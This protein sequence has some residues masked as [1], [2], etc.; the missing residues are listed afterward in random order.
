MN[1]SEIESL[2]QQLF[3]GTISGDD[4]D[5]LE[6]Q[7][8]ERPE[9]T[10]LYRDY[11]LLHHTLGTRSRL[12][13]LLTPSVEATPRLKRRM[14]K[15][16][17]RQFVT[18]LAAAIVVSAVAVTLLR[19]THVLDPRAT[20]TLVSA[21]GS[22]VS[23]DDPEGEGRSPDGAELPLGSTVRLEQGTVEL[24]FSR[25]VRSVITAPAQFTLRRDLEWDLHHGSAW[26]R[27]EPE[28]KGFT[29]HTRD[30]SVTDLGT[31]FAVVSFPDSADQVHVLKGEVEARARRGFREHATLGAGDS[32]RHTPNGRLESIPPPATPFASELPGGLHYLRFPFELEAS[33]RTTVA[34]DHPAIG[35]ITARLIQ[36]DG[37]AP[38]SRIVPGRFGS[39]I[40]FDG[41]GDRIITDWPGHYG[42]GPL[43]VA[44]WARAE[45]RPN[46]GGFAAWGLS[47]H[48]TGASVQLKFLIAPDVDALG[49]NPNARVL[50]C[51][52]GEGSGVG[53]SFSLEDS[54]WHHYAMVFAGTSEGQ[55]TGTIQLYI[56]GK[57]V[58]TRKTDQLTPPGRPPEI[59]DV[60]PLII[61]SGLSGEIGPNPAYSPFFK[62]ELD[63]L[64]II[65]G[66][67]TP[68]QIERL[69]RTNEF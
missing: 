18:S 50:R 52:T 20:L 28:A 11:A 13:R 32:R 37:R 10:K 60:D 44:C 7:L 14:K 12:R 33:D 67:L 4:R 64:I 1:R 63:E 36:S 62:G 38:E 19:V 9:L 68:E 29:V 5:Q 48:V 8:D 35:E 39:A 53:A 23:V 34:G 47:K 43:T 17:R 41:K 26:F 31:E 59:G 22:V 16:R 49:R 69:Y 56:D 51:S 42:E 54:D 21:E 30:L 15:A 46:Y 3:D 40:R 27:V 25:G 24:T 65:E 66:V 6:R 61:G 57:P 58:S 55:A 45:G 2:L